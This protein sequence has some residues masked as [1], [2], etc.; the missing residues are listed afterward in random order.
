[1]R[2][3]EISRTSMIMLMQCSE[4]LDVSGKVMWVSFRAYWFHHV[5]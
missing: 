3:K 4:F 1:M 5:S 2:K